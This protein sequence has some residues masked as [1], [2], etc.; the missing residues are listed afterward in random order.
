[1]KNDEIESLCAA[2]ERLLQAGDLNGA[3]QFCRK[4]LTV[5]SGVARALN[6]LA[7][8]SCKAGNS[9]E[10][11][12]LFWAAHL[13]RPKDERIIQNLVIVLRAIGK[14]DQAKAICQAF[15]QAVPGSVEISS[16]LDELLKG[17]PPGSGVSGP[18]QQ[19]KPF[20]SKNSVLERL[21]ALGVDIGTVIDVG[22]HEVGT[23]ELIAHFP[24]AKH[25]LFEPVDIYFEGI[26]KLYEKI[27]YELFP[28][29]CSDVNGECFLKLLASEGIRR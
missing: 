27:D 2:G 22:V 24:R 26:R 17:V 7:L 10:A 19:K 28:I 14:A 8:I 6:S 1:M 16:A 13:A 23:T 18:K 15:L 29:A 20:P 4:A 11:I 25:L 21:I 5:D 3:N 12:S 9:E